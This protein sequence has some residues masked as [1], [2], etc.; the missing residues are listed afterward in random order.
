MHY[1]GDFPL[2]AVPFMLVM[3]IGMGLMMWLMMRM[4][5]GGHGGHDSDHHDVVNGSSA[6]ELRSLRDEI[7]SL[8]RELESTRP[9][10]GGPPGGGAPKTGG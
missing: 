10:R 9:E 3:M 5:M 7:A 6:D 4:M 1:S 8:R 2:V